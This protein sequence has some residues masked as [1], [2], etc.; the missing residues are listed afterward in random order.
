M[1]GRISVPVVA[2]S[3]AGAYYVLTRKLKD[4]PSAIQ[5]IHLMVR[6]AR[7]ERATPRFEVWCSI[8]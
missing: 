2:K 5:V 1:D 3:C 8:R 6:P 4:E 7:L